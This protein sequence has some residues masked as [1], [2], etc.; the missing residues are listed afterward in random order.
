MM[1]NT[2][3]KLK[4]I[5]FKGKLLIAIFHANFQKSTT[6]KSFQQ[7]SGQKHGFETEFFAGGDHMHTMVELSDFFT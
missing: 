1:E 4:N 2:K 3:T 5:V 7:N 6:W